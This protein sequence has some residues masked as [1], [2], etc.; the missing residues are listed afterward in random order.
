ML[1]ID[2]E[3]SS[4]SGAAMSIE[5]LIIDAS[6]RIEIDTASALL[7]RGLTLGGRIE[8]EAALVRCRRRNGTRAIASLHNK[9][10]P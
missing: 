7:H 2:I 3:L 4:V 1:D 8:R 9:V 5:R 10:D 6:D